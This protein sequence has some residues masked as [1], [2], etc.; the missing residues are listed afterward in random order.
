MYTLEV[1]DCTGQV[2]RTWS[3]DD[4]ALLEELGETLVEQG[5]EVIW[6]TIAR[7]GE[8]IWECGILA[9]RDACIEQKEG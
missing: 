9:S 4:L 2:I 3:G 5:K 7:D 6:A 8:V 1:Y